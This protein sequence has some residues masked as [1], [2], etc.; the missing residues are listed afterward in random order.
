[1]VT[2]EANVHHIV[3]TA[4][5]VIVD[6]TCGNLGNRI[7][8]IVTAA[9]CVRTRAATQLNVKS[10]VHKHTT[11]TT[12]NKAR[13][14][15]LNQHRRAFGATGMVPAGVRS[16]LDEAVMAGLSAGVRNGANDIPAN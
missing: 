1:V 12:T 9:K 10:H 15:N 5:P 4:E 8:A 2:N 7:I 16:S 13:S 6:A 3:K 11:V 14:E